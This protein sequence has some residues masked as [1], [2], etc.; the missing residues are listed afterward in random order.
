MTGQ[1]TALRRRIAGWLAAACDI[2]DVPPPAVPTARIG[3]GGCG[4]MADPVRISLAATVQPWTVDQCGDS[5]ILTLG[6]ALALSVPEGPAR[7]IG[8][9]MITAADVIREDAGGGE[10]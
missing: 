7:I 3:G 9:A 10:P 5:V 1:W 2:V 8:E 6:D 4:Y